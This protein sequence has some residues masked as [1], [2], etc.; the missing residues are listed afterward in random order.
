MTWQRGR[1]L[2]EKVAEMETFRDILCRQIDT[3]QGYFDSCASAVSHGAV[4]E[5]RCSTWNKVKNSVFSTVIIWLSTMLCKS[6]TCILKLCR[7]KKEIQFVCEKYQQRI[8]SAFLVFFQYM[9]MTSGIQ[10][11]PMT[12]HV[13][14]IIKVKYSI[15]LRAKI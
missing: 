1:G 2:S 6:H 9:K 5:C 4:Q 3:L 13:D 11:T 14:Q 12:P 15:V 8:H 7:K 10:T